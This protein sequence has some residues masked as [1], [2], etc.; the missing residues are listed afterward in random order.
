[1]VWRRGLGY[2]LWLAVLVWAALLL[3]LH[4]RGAETPP[5]RIL[6]VQ[7]VVNGFAASTVAPPLTRGPGMPLDGRPAPWV[8][9]RNLAGHPVQLTTWRG[10]VVVLTFVN[11]LCGAGCSSLIPVIQ[12]AW[13]RVGRSDQLALVAVSVNPAAGAPA[14]RR[15]WGGLQGQVQ[16]TV[17]VGPKKALV[18]LWRLYG[19]TVEPG[20]T[21]LA[22]TPALYI[23]NRNGR[24]DALFIV[25][26]GL[27]AAQ[28][29]TLAEALRRALADRPSSTST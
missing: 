17:V 2:G 4:L 12:D 6:T 3:G 27:V 18:R 24:E 16:G 14:A 15:W 28:A 21:G 1:V 13:A 26:P 29:R 5:P 23:M 19:V 20:G 9:A 8:P 25:Q 22:Y 10:R 11:P 7:Q